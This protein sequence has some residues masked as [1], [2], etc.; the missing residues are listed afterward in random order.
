MGIVYEAEQ[1]N[2]R[3]SVALKLIRPGLASAGLRRRFAR[4]AQILG[5]LH[6]PSIARTIDYGTLPDGSP[7]IVME[8]LEGEALSKRLVRLGRLGPGAIP[9]C[10]RC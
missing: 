3:R 6:H 1:D 4:E 9:I 7:Y 5:R 2:P 10:R 8:H